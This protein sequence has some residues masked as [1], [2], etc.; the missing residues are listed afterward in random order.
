MHTGD[1]KK[2]LSSSQKPEYYPYLNSCRS[3]RQGSGRLRKK[4]NRVRKKKPVSRRSNK[5]PILA[6]CREREFGVVDAVQHDLYIFPRWWKLAVE[7][8]EKERR[9]QSGTRTWLHGGSL[10]SYCHCYQE[11][12]CFSSPRICFFVDRKAFRRRSENHS[13]KKKPFLFLSKVILQ[14]YSTSAPAKSASLRWNTKRSKRLN[15]EWGKRLEECQKRA[16][17]KKKTTHTRS[18]ARFLLAGLSIRGAD[19]YT[20]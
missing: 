9:E 5:N 20:S 4:E 15:T 18:S 6:A 16:H 1:L 17:N 8:T 11:S 10:H 13:Q 19:H 3:L 2:N 12:W 7:V 14:V